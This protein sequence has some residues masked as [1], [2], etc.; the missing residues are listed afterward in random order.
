M[1]FLWPLALILIGQGNNYSKW[2]RESRG[3]TAKGL[4]VQSNAGPCRRDTSL[5]RGAQLQGHPV[6]SFHR[7][8]NPWQCPCRDALIPWQYCFHAVT[9][10]TEGPLSSSL[11][12]HSLIVLIYPVTQLARFF[13]F[14]TGS[15]VQHTCWPPADIAKKAGTWCMYIYIAAITIT[16]LG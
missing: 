6:T 9:E 15:Y 14:M 4:R 1:S 12:H 10:K 2:G 5:I 3:H 16:R 8:Q 7:S 13:D 11:N